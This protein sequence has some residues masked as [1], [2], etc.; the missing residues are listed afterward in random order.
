MA[1]FRVTDQ[2][3]QALPETSFS[4]QGLKERGDLQRLLKRNIGVVADGVLVIAE[5]Y[6]DFEESRRR[7]DLLGVDRE[8]KIVVIE[9]KRGEDGGHMELQAIRYAAMVSK[10]TFEQAADAYQSFLGGAGVT[11]IGRDELLAFLGWDEPRGDQFA[12]EVRIILVSADFSKE[13][14][15]AVL[16]LREEFGVP[17]ECVKVKPY[18]SGQ[19][20]LVDVQKLIPLPEAADYQERIRQK[21]QEE[22][23]ARKDTGYWFMN[24]GDGGEDGDR[25]WEDSKRYGFMRAGGGKRYVD[26]VRRLRVGDKVFAYLSG[27]GYV[28]LGEITAEAVPFKDF[29]PAGESSPLPA[30]P[31][32]APAASR[33]R[34]EDPDKLDVCVA[35]KWLKAVDRDRGVLKN[36]AH[37]GTLCRIRRPDV[38]EELLRYFGPEEAGRE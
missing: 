30:L 15:T 14:T 26:A 5:E 31:L 8:G 22:R 23:E 17:I 6:G 19:G 25:V 36:R 27:H 37:L 16:W 28:G 24:T 33:E 11:R 29:T 9:L 7:I 32:R 2:E 10:M 4:E 3:I 20:L 35:V 18:D 21:T 13:L 1:I 38:V 34:L 12:Q